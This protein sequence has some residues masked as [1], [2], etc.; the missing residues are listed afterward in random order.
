MIVETTPV[1][2]DSGG[3]RARSGSAVTIRYPAPGHPGCPAQMPAEGDRIEVDGGA[4]VMEAPESGP[5]TV[6]AH[7]KQPGGDHAGWGPGT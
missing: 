7:L 4:Y 6:S 1:E 5:I 3:L 2:M